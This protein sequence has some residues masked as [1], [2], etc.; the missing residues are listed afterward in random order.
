MKLI[1]ENSDRESIYV[2]E[3][4]HFVFND[5]NDDTQL[6]TRRIDGENGK[7][8]Y[9]ISLCPGKCTLET[10]GHTRFTNTDA[11]LTQILL[12]F[13]ICLSRVSMVCDQTEQVTLFYLW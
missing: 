8:Y 1:L 2:E 10:F 6:K 3:L 5:A 4:L 9:V 11:T 7:F 13:C 12:L